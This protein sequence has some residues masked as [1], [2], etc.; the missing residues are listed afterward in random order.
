MESG[1]NH[2][3]HPSIG[4]AQPARKRFPRAICE[5]RCFGLRRGIPMERATGKRVRTKGVTAEIGLGC[6][7]AEEEEKAAAGPVG[8]AHGRGG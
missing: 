2:P 8:A 1:A 3:L 7:E 4:G 6:N 5:S